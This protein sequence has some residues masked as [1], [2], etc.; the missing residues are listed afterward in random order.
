MGAS[1]SFAF[2]LP[3]PTDHSKLCLLYTDVLSPS[4]CAEAIQRIEQHN[5]TAWN[6]V[7]QGGTPLTGRYIDSLANPGPL[8]PLLWSRVASKLP[9]QL[10][11]GRRLVG[12]H[13]E[14]RV[15]KYVT[16]GSTP[17]HIDAIV[18]STP[19]QVQKALGTK[20]VVPKS[21]KSKFI[22]FFLNAFLSLTSVFFSHSL[23]TFIVFSNYMRVLPMS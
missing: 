14:I 10:P 17:P 4:E 18:F 8:L 6:P 11:N 21:I 19:R 16:G 12:P 23:L 2:S 9:K 13:P 1:P 22:D 7:L 15:T 3:D 5:K 20:D